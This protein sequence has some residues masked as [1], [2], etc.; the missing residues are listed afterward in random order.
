M[1]RTEDSSTQPDPSC[2]AR[3]GLVS[4]LLLSE[5]G[6]PESPVRPIA[7]IPVGPVEVRIGRRAREE[8]RGGDG[9]ALDD[10]ASHREKV[11]LRFPD[12][13]LSRAHLR[14]VR[15][16]AGLVVV[17]EGSL[18]G[19]FLADGAWSARRGWATGRTS[20]SESRSGVFRMITERALG[21]V[22][23]EQRQ[24]GLRAVA[25]LS[26]TLAEALALLRL[27]SLNQANVVLLGETGWARRSARVR[28]T[29]P[30]HARGASWR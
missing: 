24:V 6:A 14:I 23:A 15:R 25:P 8:C 11:E 12:S 4:V 22:E 19:T 3:R 17:D 7:R 1:E 27:S 9:G 20:V 16:T 29:R 28:C 21:A 26:P 18:N 2:E 13:S 5:L 30:W 10:I